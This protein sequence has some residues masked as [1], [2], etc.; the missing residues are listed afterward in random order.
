MW[1]IFLFSSAIKLLL[2]DTYRSTDFEVHRNWLAITHSL[3]LSRWYYEDT[4]I[5]TLDYP[6]AFA[7]F[8]YILSCL[9]VYWDPAML[10][11]ANLN[12]AS[13]NTVLFQRFSV[14]ATDLVLYYAV[15]QYVS[16]Q[17][18]THRQRHTCVCLVVLN[19]GLLL[20]DH[21]HFQYNSVLLGLLVLS[22][23][24]IQQG[25]V[26]EGAFLYTLLLNMKH[27]YLG[28]APA[29]GI[30]LLRSYCFTQKGSFA[31]RRFLRL[32]L[33]VVFTTALS[34]GPIILSMVASATLPISMETSDS[35]V[36]TVPAMNT[37]FKQIMSR[38]FPFHRGLLHAY[39]APNVWA[40]YAFLDKVLVACR[41]L[42]G[43]HSKHTS[44][45]RSMTSGVVGEAEFVLL[46]HVTPSV[47]VA[48]ILAA[49]V[50]CL[51]GLWLACVPDPNCECEAE[52]VSASTSGQN[53][54]GEPLTPSPVVGHV[55]TTG[56]RQRV[57]SNPGTATT[58]TGTE[59]AIKAETTENYDKIHNTGRKSGGSDD[60]AGSGQLGR[61]EHAKVNGDLFLRA[62]ALCGLTVFLLGWHVHEKAVLTGL[63]PVILLSTTNAN[64]QRVLM[65]L[66]L[67]GTYALF[68][69]LYM[70][71]EVPVK[72]SLLLL[73]TGYAY[74]AFS[75]S[76]KANAI[77][78][79]TTYLSH[80]E[81]AYMLGFLG[82]WVYTTLLHT[83]LFGD[84]MEFVPLL[85]TSVYSAL[86]VLYAY[87]CIYVDTLATCMRENRKA[88]IKRE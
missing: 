71:Q 7:W 86:G 69:L 46:P 80:L 28:L 65:V 41:K 68:P 18:I 70:P 56:L 50:P 55:S 35:N 33:L 42:I 85:M 11:I 48:L 3:P 17:F 37:A 88:L 40:L 84:A 51:C 8:E 75:T 32:G 13:R 31:Y 81:D 43:P 20:L 30:Y 62:V 77:S 39:W 19:C 16:T 22:I 83:A 26:L 78:S 66:S 27:L 38:L 21:I 61:I 12:Y 52:G 23:T 73:Y 82:L 64:L 25:R 60:D 57:G 36:Y 1:R 47:T 49:L 67:S 5:W 34:F 53:I 45:S 9:A 4:S 54:G 2:L 14:I 74:M 29:F 6:P 44:S 72:A 10:Q 59:S 15:T 79:H 24:R 58:P 63:L 76:C 87:V